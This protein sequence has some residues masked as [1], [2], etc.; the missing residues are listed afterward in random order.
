M[1]LTYKKTTSLTAHGV[2][3]TVSVF[4]GGIQN[5]CYMSPVMEKH[6]LVATCSASL[7]TY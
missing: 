1:K 6:Y 2:D 5:E 7:E 3:R 4:L